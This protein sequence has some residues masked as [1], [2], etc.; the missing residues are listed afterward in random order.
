MLLDRLP[1]LPKTATPAEA[2]KLLRVSRAT[3]LRWIQRDKLPH[4]R[5]GREIR[6]DLSPY[7]PTNVNETIAKARGEVTGTSAAE[8]TLTRIAAMLGAGAPADDMIAKLATPVPPAPPAA[9]AAPWD[10]EPV[11]RFDVE[12]PPWK[13]G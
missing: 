1:I 2:A 10:G 12:P 4:T 9:G 6:I 8:K 11:A 3:I 13:T 5:V 7:Y